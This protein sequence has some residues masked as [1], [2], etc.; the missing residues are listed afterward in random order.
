VRQSAAELA[1]EAHILDTITIDVS[2]CPGAGPVGGTMAKFDVQNEALMGHSMGATISPLALAFEPRFKG[3]LLSGAGGSLIQNVM[4]KLEPLAVLGLVGD[5]VGV[6]PTAGYTLNEHDPLLSMIQWA[7]EPSDPPIYARRIT[8]E[9][10]DGPARNVL[11]MQGIVDHYIMPPIANA[12]SLAMGLQLAGAELDD[13]TANAP[14]YVLTQCGCDSSGP[15]VNSCT[16]ECNDATKFVMAGSA[17]ATCLGAAIA[18][19]SSTCVPVSA[20]APVGTLQPLVG[21]S[22]ASLP[23]TANLTTKMGKVTAVLTQNQGDGTEDGHEVAF[24]T[25]GPKHQYGCFLKSLLTGTPTVPTPGMAF[26]PC[27]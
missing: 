21:A 2:N 10:E 19:K 14:N 18:D 1:L 12:V 4:Y 13:T 25:D 7:C 15:C 5:L 17:C 22:A 24:Q 20:L 23:V 8:L 9:P 6:P 16:N 26:D 27:N 3:G 11:M